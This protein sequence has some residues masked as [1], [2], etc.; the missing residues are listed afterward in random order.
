ME[1]IARAFALV[2]TGAGTGVDHRRISGVDD[3]GKYVRVVDHA[4]VDVLPMG[5]CIGGLP[6]QVPSPR[7]DDIGI[8]GIDGD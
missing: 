8:L 7:I 4:L 5:A 6:R 1:Q 3:N 2:N